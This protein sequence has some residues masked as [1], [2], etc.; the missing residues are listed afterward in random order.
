MFNIRSMFHVCSTFQTRSM[1]CLDVL[2]LT[3][4]SHAKVF[5]EAE[6]RQFPLARS[7]DHAINFKPGSPSSLNCKVYA[8]TPRERTNLQ[9]WLDDMLLEL[10]TAR[11]HSPGR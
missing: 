6:S 2:Y 10:S 5:S 11:E 4:I 8:T 9:E 1:F 7:W 3:H